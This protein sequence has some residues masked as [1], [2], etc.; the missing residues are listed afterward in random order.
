[1]S[2]YQEDALDEALPL[3]QIEDE[4]QS[5]DDRENG[6]ATPWR[7]KVLTELTTL[8]MPPSEW[9]E[10]RNQTPIPPTLSSDSLALLL[11]QDKPKPPYSRRVF[12]NRQLRLD[13]IDWIGFDMDYTILRYSAEPMDK[14]SYDQGLA[15]LMELGYDK[16]IESFQYNPQRAMRGLLIDKEKGNLLQINRHRHVAAAYHGHQPLGKEE[17]KQT[18]RRSPMKFSNSPNSKTSKKTTKSPRF[19]MIDSLFGVPEACLYS[20]L[21][22]WQEQQNKTS[23][24]LD[25]LA[26][27][28]DV[29][30]AMDQAHATGSIHQ[31][32]RNDFDK[33]IIKDP[34]VSVTLERLR[35]SG[36]QLFLLTNSDW[37]Y[38]DAAMTYLLDGQIEPQRRW[39]DFF[40]LV[41]VRSGKP[42]FFRTDEPFEKLD[43]AGKTVGSNRSILGHK[44]W[45][46]GNQEDL[47]R[48][49]GEARDRV[50]YIGDHI[51]GDILRTK[52][53]SA[54]RTM[55][56]V[57]ELER[58]LLLLQEIKDQWNSWE[59]FE[60]RRSEL[61]N[62]HNDL[63][64][65]LERLQQFETPTQTKITLQDKAHAAAVERAERQLQQVQRELDEVVEKSTV[66]LEQINQR[67]NPYW[68]MLFREGHQY[69]YL[70]EQVRS[71]ACLYTSRMTNL[72]CYTSNQY[73][74]PPLP[75][76]PHEMP[77][78]R[79]DIRT[80]KEKSVKR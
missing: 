2:S 67:F 38:T 52:K 28:Q 37:D 57:E 73:F 17:R 29:R 14:L 16:E 15:Q 6:S 33:Y 23:E 63:Q 30:K 54:W 1:M 43:N 35:A 41:I 60:E 76:L 19:R 13:R 5:S 31:C 78:E 45:R 42:R 18:Y 79:G 69:S 20:D 39:H 51:F 22:E 49:L 55:L 4:F 59:K 56:V 46:G 62:S 58:E 12:A 25:Y 72:L 8:S 32:I 61:N 9:E 75:L 10:L 48:F 3:Q 44:F 7:G 34:E 21:V 53:S 36:K 68:G 71:F 47:D 80:P 74:R 40:E 66:L 11:A 70:G 64:V 24:P 26:L 65:L 77:E 27:Y 50:L